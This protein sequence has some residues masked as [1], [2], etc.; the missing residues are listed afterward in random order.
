MKRE[1]NL[2]KVILKVLKKKM[3]KSAKLTK[4]K[5]EVTLMKMKELPRKICYL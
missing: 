5:K 2:K 3:M 4:L 1:Q